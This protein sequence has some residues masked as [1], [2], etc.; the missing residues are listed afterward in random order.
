MEERT[1]ERRRMKILCLHGFRTSGSFLEKQ[2]SKWDPSIFHHHFDMEFPDGFYPAGGKSDIEGI[3]PPPYFEWF[4]FEKDFTVYTNLEECISY[5][6]EYMTTKGPFDG[7]LGF[8]QGATLSALLLG[9]QAQGKVLK[10]HPPIKL[11]VSISGSKFRDP[12]ICQIAY[13]DPIKV[14]SVHFIGAKDWLR[15]PSEDLATSFHNPLI[16]RHPQGHTVPRLDED[17][18]EKLR[19]WTKEILSNYRDNA[20]AKVENSNLH[21][22]ACK[23]LVEESGD[24]MVKTE[25]GV[26][27]T[28]Q[29]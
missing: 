12:S 9:Y 13:K 8:S 23:I 17:A 14:R 1:D 7:L 2:I 11:F 16:I 21:E 26:A 28:I 25:A 6:C 15:L 10:D 4:Q 22:A 29:A 27:E 19:G 18:V 20:G 5:L 3:F 24:L